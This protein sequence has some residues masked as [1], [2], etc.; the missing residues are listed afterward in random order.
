MASRLRDEDL[1]SEVLQLLN[2]FKNVI[3]GKVGALLW[4]SGNIGVPTPAQ[5]LNRGDI[6]HS[7]VKEIQ[8]FWHFLVEELPVVPDA[9]AAK[10]GLV[11]IHPFAKE[12][13]GGLFRFSCACLLYTSPSPRDATLSRMPSSA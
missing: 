12:S 1:L 10:G 5:F 2:G 6:D 3:K 11:F 4:E 9:V 7:V 8:Q 13:E